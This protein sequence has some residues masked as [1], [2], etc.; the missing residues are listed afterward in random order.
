MNGQSEQRFAQG[1]LSTPR[2]SQI[3][4]AAVDRFDRSRDR[5]IDSI[6][7][8]DSIF[9]GFLGH[10]GVNQNVGDV[11]IC[12]LSKFQPCTTLGGRK[13]A[14]K[15]KRKKFEIFVK[16]DSIDSIIGSI[17]SI[18]PSV[19]VVGRPGNG[20]SV[21]LSTTQHSALIRRRI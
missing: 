21:I 14:K 15:P 2:T 1:A 13:N 12:V 19:G 8:I 3:I 16:F 11:E 17:R 7:T 10:P 6:D 18:M 9:S 4:T 20:S 5:S